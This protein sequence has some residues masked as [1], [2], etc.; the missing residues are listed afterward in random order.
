MNTRSWVAHCRIRSAAG[1]LVLRGTRLVQEHHFLQTSARLT[2]ALLLLSMPRKAEALTV[3]ISRA[4]DSVLLSWSTQSGINYSVETA[5]F[6][7]GPWSAQTNL[8][9]LSNVLTWIDPSPISVPQRFYRLV[10]SASVGF[11]NALLAGDGLAQQVIDAAVAQSQNCADAVFLASQQAASGQVIANGTLTQSSAGSFTYDTAPSD[12][13]IVQLTNGLA[14]TYYVTTMQGDFSGDSGSF[15]QNP[16]RFEFRTVA[17][18]L[19]MS[20]TSMT[21]DCNGGS[22]PNTSGTAQG[23]FT[24]SNMTYQAALSLD[25]N[26][27]F[28][29][30]TT[31]TELKEDYTV[32]G[33][34]TGAGLELVLNQRRYFDAVQGSGPHGFASTAQDWIKNRLSLGSDLY[35]WHNVYKERSFSDLHT[36]N[37]QP[38]NFDPLLSPLEWAAT[39]DV[40]KNGAPF[41]AYHYNFDRNNDLYLRFQLLTPLGVIDLEKYQWY[42]GPRFADYPTRPGDQK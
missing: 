28:S 26:Y 1:R 10:E 11:T 15:I 6:A 31:G 9:T 23:T 40:L 35:E 37:V 42:F 12:K 13:L 41:A 21:G 27:C 16:H 24:L 29:S 18:D 4:A 17:S 25:G 36:A 5:P 2:A 19:D 8:T 30:D 20:F 39:G 38:V 7:T 32:T 14:T 33:K 34:I 22:A 3:Q